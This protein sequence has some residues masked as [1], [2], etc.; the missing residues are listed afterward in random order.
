MSEPTSISFR[1]PYCQVVL[2][3]D[4]DL[5]GTTGPCPTCGESIRAPQLPNYGGSFPPVPQTAPGME[6]KQSPSSTPHGKEDKKSVPKIQ[7][8]EV[9]KATFSEVKQPPAYK[10]EKTGTQVIHEK[11]NQERKLPIKFFVRALLPIFLTGAVFVLI[12]GIRKVMMQQGRGGPKPEETA[13]EN[14][15]ENPD[16]AAGKGDAANQGQ[17]SRPQERNSSAPEAMAVLEEFLKT[18]TLEER[19][20]LIETDLTEEELANTMLNKRF[21]EFRN[22]TVESQRTFP[23]ENVTDYFFGMEFV[24]EDGSANPQLMAVRSR[25]DLEPKV[26]VEPVLDLFGGRLAEYASEPKDI[27][28]TFYVVVTALPSCNDARIPNRGKKLT[29]KLMS[30]ETSGDP[31]IAYASKVSDIGEMLSRGNYDLTYGK[32]EP[33]VVLLGWNTDEQPDAPYLE[34]LDIQT[35]NWNP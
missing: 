25:G 35:T 29:L 15:V 19:L 16:N 17:N 1:C 6:A 2:T 33:C 31:I 24:R 7:P 27:G 3:V 18:K 34:A 26:L 30:H 28:R 5:V 10:P 9:R 20:P 22:I 8:R 12:V 13:S 21:P 23:L 4:V 14:G 11:P 32:A